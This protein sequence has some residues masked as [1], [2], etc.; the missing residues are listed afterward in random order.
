ME[1][2]KTEKYIACAVVEKLFLTFAARSLV[3]IASLP[4]ENKSKHVAIDFIS[5]RFYA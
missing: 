3:N 5:L 2:W 1:M 4:L